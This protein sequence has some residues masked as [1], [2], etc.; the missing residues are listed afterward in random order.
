MFYYDWL[1]FGIYT[2]LKGG[3]FSKQARDELTKVIAF[4]GFNTETTY[5]VMTIKQNVMRY[6]ISFGT[7]TV[8]E[9]SCDWIV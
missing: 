7:H 5:L 4:V 8:V 3:R 2:V 9:T 1:K 6:G